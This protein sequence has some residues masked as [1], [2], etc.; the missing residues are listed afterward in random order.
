MTAGD[1][2]G[3]HCEQ[4]DHDMNLERTRGRIQIVRQESLFCHGENWH[5]TNKVASLRPGAPLN[6]NEGLIVVS[7]PATELVEV[8]QLKLCVCEV[9][10][11]FD[12]LKEADGKEQVQVS[13]PAKAYPFFFSTVRSDKFRPPLFILRKLGTLVDTTSQESCVGLELS[14][15]CT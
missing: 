7:R 9:K 8:V 14:C 1:V 5:L 6:I 11:K 4:R 13:P 10:S 2:H 3:R 15:L 12:I